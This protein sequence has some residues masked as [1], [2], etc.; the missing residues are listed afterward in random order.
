M[1]R[2]RK[3]R[4]WFGLTCNYTI[5]GMVVKVF[6][7]KD[8]V[9][10]GDELERVYRPRDDSKGMLHNI[11]RNYCR[12]AILEATRSLSSMFGCNKPSVIVGDAR[13]CI[14]VGGSQLVTRRGFYRNLWRFHPGFRAASS[15]R[16]AER[17]GKGIKPH[18]AQK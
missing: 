7:E 3:L 4:L 18:D 5:G 11:I 1:S 8:R 2:A 14:C 13:V 12:V 9:H 6:G 15:C 10:F 16:I 17:P